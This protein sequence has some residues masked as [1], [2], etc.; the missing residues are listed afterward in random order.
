MPNHGSGH[1]AHEIVLGN[2]A[3]DV[4]DKTSML[5]YT[6]DSPP[7]MN[8]GGIPIIVK[9]AQI[10]STELEQSV[11]MVDWALQSNEVA[12]VWFART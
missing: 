6:C 1:T 3:Y 11:E 4:T 12:P 10:A 8:D 7:V 2:E 5:Q 9:A